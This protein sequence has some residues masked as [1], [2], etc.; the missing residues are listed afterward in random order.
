M[1]ELTKIAPMILLLASCVGEDLPTVTHQEE[2]LEKLGSALR[3]DGDVIASISPH[4]VSGCMVGAWRMVGS[5][6][7]S[8]TAQ[9]QIL[10]GNQCDQPFTIMNRHENVGD[11]IARFETS[12]GTAT[13]CG[14]FPEFTNWVAVEIQPGEIVTLYA[15]MDGVK[16][17]TEDD[18]RTAVSLLWPRPDGLAPETCC[19]LECD[20]KTRIIE[21]FEINLSPQSEEY[22]TAELLRKQ[23]SEL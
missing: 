7:G 20:S 13:W 17:D 19:S 5:S 3:S 11:V 18:L 12:V 4:V 14:W 2:V 6:L 22:L 21:R 8:T 16:L 23:R 10:V 15:P 1:K 9:S